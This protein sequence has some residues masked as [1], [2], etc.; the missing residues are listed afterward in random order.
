MKYPPLYQG[1]QRGREL[2]SKSFLMWLVKSIYQGFVI[3][4]MS[5]AYFRSPWTEMVTVAYT[6]LI[7]I[8]ILNVMSEVS[9]L[10]KVV[11]GSCLGSL[12][13]YV[14]SLYIIPDVL[15]VEG[16]DWNFWKMVTVNVLLAWAPLYILNW[17]AYVYSPTKDQKLMAQV[18]STREY[19]LTGLL[20]K[21]MF[22]KK[23]DINDIKKEFIEM[24]DLN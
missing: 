23:Q 16:M 12:F 8:E 7:F 13:V 3:M 19:G 15:G 6:S 11:L 20:K 22:W 21:L 17:L 9:R 14:A 5:T 24:R 1:L 10:N 18:G 2:T 4:M